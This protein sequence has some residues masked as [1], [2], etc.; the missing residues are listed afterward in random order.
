MPDGNYALT[1]SKM[2]FVHNI[3][4][5]EGISFVPYTLELIIL[6][7]HSWPLMERGNSRTS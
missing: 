1:V 6:Q 5:I 4:G 2:F 3:H 7:L